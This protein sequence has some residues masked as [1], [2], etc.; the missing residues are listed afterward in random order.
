MTAI[1]K[2]IAEV[3]YDTQDMTGSQE[4]DKLQWLLQIRPQGCGNPPR[5]P[6]A[7]MKIMQTPG[8]LRR[9]RLLQRRQDVYRP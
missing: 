8:R 7:R 5:P 4:A 1:Q 3:G 6:A 9:K 2:A